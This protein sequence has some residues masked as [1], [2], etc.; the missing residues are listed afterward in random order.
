VTVR[1]LFTAGAI[2]TTGQTI[3]YAGT[4]AQIGS[5]TPA[6]GGDATITYSWRSSA[7]G[8]TAAISGAT[9]ATFTPPAGL[10]TTT[11]YQRYA[12]DGTCNTSPSIS[13]GT[14]TVTV[15]PLFTAGAI[16][17]TGQ[18][19]CYGGDPAVI[20]SATPASGGDGTITYKWQANGVDIDGATEASYN[21]PSGLTANTTYT[22]WAH[23][24]TC[25]TSFAQSSNSW[26][27][28]INPLPTLTSAAL[29][30]TEGVCPGN[31]A[32]INL[33]GLLANTTNSITY[34]INGG[35]NQTASGVVANALGEGSFTTVNLTYANN[36]QK[37]TI[38]SVSITSNT[39][40]CDQSFSKEVILVVK[41]P[42]TIETPVASKTSWTYG[43]TAANI[44]VVADGEGTLTYEWKHKYLGATTTVG[45]NSST[46]TVPELAG[47]GTHE[48]WVV[49]TGECGSATSA[50]VIITINPQT[51]S[52]SGDAYYT[53]PIVAYT[54]NSTANTATFTLSAFIQNSDPDI[55][56]GDIATARLSFSYKVAG[57]TAWTKVPN[58]QNLPVNYV[59]PAYPS[60]GGT[61]AVIAQLN[62]G[63][64][65]TEL[66]DIL[67]TISGN[68]TG[69]NA[70]SETP[71]T[72]TQPLPG[73]TISGGAKLNNTSSTG[74]VKG[75]NRTG[76]GFFVNYTLKSGKAQ[77]P[78]GKVNLKVKSNYDRF[79]KLTS[80][81]HTYKITSNAIASMSISGTNATFTSKANIAEIINCET[82][83]T[84]SMEGNCTLVME[85]VDV[86]SNDNN[87]KDMVGVV[88][89]RN[90]GGIWYSNN[91]TSQG[92]TVPTPINCGYIYVSNSGV[93]E[94]TK[95]AVILP[96]QTV[97]EVTT[98]K[99][100]PNPFTDRLNIEFSSATDGMAK[101]EIYGV[102]GA[103]LATLWDAPV[104]GGVLNKVEYLPNLVSSQM[105]FYHLTMDGKTQVGK[106]VF[107][108]RR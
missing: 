47:A 62:I 78:K 69:D 89:Y 50:H 45:T 19:I 24:G 75:I 36:G 93:T 1:P 104:T 25:N 53:G 16:E 51:A 102:T 83:E 87:Q 80:D 17:T 54:A 66:Y 52:A 5:A 97:T 2:E 108:E 55:N 71:I 84:V 30:N 88:V 74:F 107:Q 64:G 82:G 33:T 85:L 105:V 13:S 49:V 15:R 68:Y 57:T 35:T 95:S 73:G 39:P 48:Y 7:D 61:A 28:M 3:C 81:V 101:L 103:K 34:N 41:K 67:V 56:C 20:G 58:G 79:G 6:T 27:V 18:T 99:A 29:D 40:T 90:S 94:C 21:P 46:Y 38:T 70:L 60:K 92:K 4:P 44:T 65:T 106:V 96:D 22:R 11:S 63:N 42:T 72:I 32:K 23:D 37:L 98:V 8:Y 14:W 77:N 9:S 86:C 12:N 43:C 26:A 10:T 31:G 91:Y 100:Y 59:D 76:L